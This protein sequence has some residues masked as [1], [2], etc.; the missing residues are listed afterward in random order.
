MRH[1]LAIAALG[2]AT[3]SLAA[4]PAA[5]ADDTLKLGYL[6]GVP[7]YLAPY[8]QPSL[9]GVEVAVDEINKAGGIGGK[10]KIELIERDM[11]SDT[12]QA[13]IMAQELV[14]EG[15]EVLITPCDVDPSIAAG[16][17]TQ[18][19]EVAAISS[20]ASTPTLPATVGPY[21]FSNY[22]ADNLQAAVLAD[23]SQKQGYKT[24]YVLLSPDTPYTQ[25]L[26]EYFIVAFKNKG[27]Q[28]LGVSEYTMGQQDFS[29]EVTKIANM[30]PKPD[31]IMT[32]AYEPDF[33]AFIRQLRGAGVDAPV[34]GSDGIDSPT[35]FALGEVAEGVVFTNAGFPTEGSPLAAFYKEFEAFHGQPAETAF[36]A[37]GYDIVKV[38]AAA[39][40]AA[41]STEPAAIRDA[42]N[43]V[44]GVE[45]ATGKITYKGMNRVPLR[46]VALN[47]IVG[48]KVEHV[49]DEVPAAADV[50]S[51]DSGIRQ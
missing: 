20:C 51:P 4:L 32:S 44:E 7:G 38:I 49:A 35:T 47:R 36:T 16:M 30:D 37:T 23:Y 27:G 50:P 22:T 9:A 1:N 40:E 10:I 48:G 2:A 43:E 31:V 34:L 25:R 14:N 28:V 42:L 26:P 11:R 8:D 6:G 5:G 46:T 33:P 39:V 18:A 21:M 45:A 12:A 29:A 19:S 24:A 15:V 13:G 17:I 41:G 3:L